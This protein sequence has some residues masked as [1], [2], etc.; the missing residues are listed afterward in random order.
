MAPVAEVEPR[1]ERISKDVEEW[2]IEESVGTDVDGLE[3]ACGDGEI[4]TVGLSRHAVRERPT[5]AMGASP[6]CAI[7]RGD[8]KPGP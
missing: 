1:D 4:G 5:W 8:D 2:C 7:S 3:G 6:A